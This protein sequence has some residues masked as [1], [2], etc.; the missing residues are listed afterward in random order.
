M[1]DQQN[2]HGHRF[3]RGCSDCYGIILLIMDHCY[4]LIL[5]SEW[6]QNAGI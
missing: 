6:V 1:V 4:S 2:V 3:D 5:S